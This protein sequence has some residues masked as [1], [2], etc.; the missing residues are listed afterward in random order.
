MRLTSDQFGDEL[1]KDIEGDKNPAST[2]TRLDQVADMVADME[3]KITDKIEQANKQVIEHLENADV[4]EYTNTL[5]EVT[6]DD[7][8]EDEKEINN[9]D[10][11]VPDSQSEE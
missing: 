6:A 8:F 10:N 11:R 1:V 3:K 5:Q 2:S 7:E 4:P 9:E